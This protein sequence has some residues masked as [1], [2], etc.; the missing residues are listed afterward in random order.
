MELQPTAAAAHSSLLAASPVAFLEPTSKLNASF[1]A[2]A[3]RYLDPVAAG[4]SESQTQRQKDLRKR[5]R[6][7]DYDDDIKV[8]SLK[9]VHLEGFGVHQV[10]EQMR[11]IVEAA[12]DEIELSLPEQEEEGAVAIGD[13]EDGD[14]DEE[15][16][17]AE[18]YHSESSLGEQGVDWEYDGVDDD[19]DEDA[20][21]EA[22]AE[23]MDG[24]QEYDVEM[25]D[26]EDGIFSDEDEGREP[27]AIYQPDPNG[28][29]D[30]F[31]SIDDFNKQSSFL[32]QQDQRGEGADS[33]N[34]EINWEADPMT[35][36]QANGLSADA[37][38]D[39]SDGSGPTFG[40]VDLNAPEGDSDADNDLDLDGL[41]EGMQANNVMYQDFFAPPAQKA[42]GKGKPKGHRKFANEEP[43]KA[44]E[45]EEDVEAVAARVHRD[46]FE[47]DDGTDSEGDLSDVGT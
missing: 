1:L 36:G 26:E 10:F 6:G 40:N 18:E 33:E 43:T 5:K 37:S 9:K 23:A 32:E 11:K 39:D 27:A 22:E 15:L 16:E 35:D 8:L 42:N 29:N 31:F 7:A 47:D 2:A 46:L 34:E 12:A 19:E 25:E 17:D 44:E 20:E 3:K 41:D 14:E 21:A 30:G 4:I 28:L 38:D 24:E 13:D 45:I